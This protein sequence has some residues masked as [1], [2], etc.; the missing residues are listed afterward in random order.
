[1]TVGLQK[2]AAEHPLAQLGAKQMGIVYHTDIS[3]SISAAIV[4]ETPVPTAFA[5]LRDVVG[6]YAGARR[7]Q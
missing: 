4:E 6:I 3:G 2:L 7:P 5:M 1:L